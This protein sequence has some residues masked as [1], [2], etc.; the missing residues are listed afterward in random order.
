MAVLYTSLL[1]GLIWPGNAQ[2]GLTAMKRS[3]DS[4]LRRRLP[5]LVAHLEGLPG[6]GS[7]TLE[8]L[9]D[10]SLVPMMLTLGGGLPNHTRFRA[11][12]A[13]FAAGIPAMVATTTATLALLEARLLACDELT[14]VRIVVEH[15]YHIWTYNPRFYSLEVRIVVEQG[16][17]GLH[18]AGGLLAEGRRIYTEMELDSTWGGLW[19]TNLATASGESLVQAVRAGDLPEIR[20]LIAGGASSSALG[21]D[22]L[23]A[24]H[25]AAQAG[26]VAVLPLLVD[27]AWPARGKAGGKKHASPLEATVEALVGPSWERRGNS[28]GGTPLHYAVRAKAYGFLKEFFALI[29]QLAR[30]VPALEGLDY[31]GQT[32]LHLASCGDSSGDSS[33]GSGGLDALLWGILLEVIQDTKE[34]GTAA[35]GEGEMALAKLLGAGRVDGLTALHLVAGSGEAAVGE[36]GD[37]AYRINV[38]GALVAAGAEV[39]SP[40][41]EAGWTPLHYAVHRGRWALCE[42]LL[43]LRADINA[44]ARDGSSPLHVAAEVGNEGVGLALLAAGADPNLPTLVGGCIPFALVARRGGNGAGC[45]GGVLRHA[46]SRLLEEGEEGEEGEMMRILLEDGNKIA[47][48]L[49]DGGTPEAR[50]FLH[51]AIDA[52]HALEQGQGGDPLRPDS[53]GGEAL[54]AEIVTKYLTPGAWST[55]QGGDLIRGWMSLPSHFSA[56]EKLSEGTLHG[57]RREALRRL[58]GPLKVWKKRRGRRGSLSETLYST[59]CEMVAGAVGT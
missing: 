52:H 8:V 38:T 42:T 15:Y 27:P 5:G 24:F 55:I 28:P 7:L 16:I 11:W 20:I 10:Q 59:F 44:V 4:L 49:E 34:N 12:D 3:L 57:L 9:F 53:G 6:S 37:E 54:A 45:L 48:M 17:G 1:P 25:V 14:E 21:P 19:R 22:G 33:S 35:G 2:P 36:Q 32:V 13:L 29:S 23:S 58:A 39:T 18:D 26:H 56:D 31:H 50:R 40:G 43:A 47:T 46:S 41:G 30:V 51:L